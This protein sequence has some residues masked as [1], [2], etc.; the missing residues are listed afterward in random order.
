MQGNAL[1]LINLRDEMLRRAGNEPMSDY[2]RERY[3][4]LAGAVDIML[5]QGYNEE[6]L[7]RQVDHFKG[8]MVNFQIVINHG[9]K[10]ADGTLWDDEIQEDPEEVKYV[11]MTLF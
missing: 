5:R 3:T 8:N 9:I 4:D 10:L 11:Q 7:G 6:Q 2:F 1:K